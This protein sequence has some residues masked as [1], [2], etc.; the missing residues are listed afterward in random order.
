[1][2]S[3]SV[4][5]FSGQAVRYAKVLDGY[6]ASFEFR[7]WRQ[8]KADYVE[9]V[10]SLDVCAKI[11]LKRHLEIA[12]LHSGVVKKLGRDKPVTGEPATQEAV[13]QLAKELSVLYAVV[14]QL[15][16]V[17]DGQAMGYFDPATRFKSTV[18]EPLVNA[19]KKFARA[20]KNM[21][22]VGKTANLVYQR[23]R[24]LSGMIRVGFYEVEILTM[25]KIDA[26]IN[27]IWSSPE[28]R[29]KGQSKA[30]EGGS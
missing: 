26:C 11:A 8:V 2:V 7:K 6:Y 14:E 12:P 1:M 20:T 13:I 15:K 21:D 3:S 16:I 9:A 4:P 10:D 24:V 29:P 22:Q 25:K 23:S 30:A 28:E 27:R 19:L 17:V 5:N 18:K